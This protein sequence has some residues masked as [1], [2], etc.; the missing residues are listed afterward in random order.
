MK[1]LPSSLTDL[2]IGD[3]GEEVASKLDSSIFAFLPRNMVAL[4]LPL[5]H[6]DGTRF[7][8]LPCMLEKLILNGTHS[9]LDFSSL[10]K[11]PPYLLYISLPLP[12]AAADDMHRTWEE[13]IINVF[14]RKRVCVRYFSIGHPISIFSDY[15]VEPSYANEYRS[16]DEDTTG[17]RLV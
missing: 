8:D 14:L 10:N 4:I 2:S 6:V 17:N 13:E 11:L 9:D 3:E 16:D 15:R 7:E 12:L 5:S 1:S